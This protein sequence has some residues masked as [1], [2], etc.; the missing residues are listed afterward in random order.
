MNEAA[1]RVSSGKG[2]GT[3]VRRSTIRERTIVLRMVE[4]LAATPA[5]RGEEW[6][7]SKNPNP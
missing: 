4:T 1:S 2:K 3:G 6:V 5:D 7:S